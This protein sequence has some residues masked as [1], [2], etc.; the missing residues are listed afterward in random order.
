MAEDIE[1]D[2]RAEIPARRHELIFETYH[3]LA[4]GD[5]FVLVNDHDP[6]PLYY[7]FVAEQAGKF[8]W[9][10]LEEGPER[11]RVRIGRTE[12]EA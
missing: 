1:L 12:P 10:A 2:V 5:A 7:Q 8:T 3:G 11:W 6:K 4:A 9:D